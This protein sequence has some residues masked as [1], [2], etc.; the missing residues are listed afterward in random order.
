MEKHAAEMVTLLAHPDLHTFVPTDPPQLDKLKSQYKYWEARISPQGDELWLNWIGRLKSNGQIVGHFQAGAKSSG[1][2]SIAYTIGKDYQ[3][4]GLAYEGLTTVIAFLFE[5]VQ[6]TSVKAWI[7]TRNEVSIALVRKLG[8][9]QQ[10]FIAKADHFK[11]K[12]SDEY[13]FGISGM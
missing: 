3:R 2:S 1:E 11:G 7:D 12:D 13:V 10:D 6:A 4:R 9:V 8:M 5:H